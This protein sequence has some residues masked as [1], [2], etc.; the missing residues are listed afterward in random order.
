MLLACVVD[1]DKI[2]GYPINNI[3]N[4][5]NDYLSIDF[6]G[7]DTLA[8]LHLRAYATCEPDSKSGGA[9]DETT[10]GIF[11]FWQQPT[12][13]SNKVRCPA[14]YTVTV[15]RA[16]IVVGGRRLN[17][18]IAG[19]GYLRVLYADDDLRVFVAPKSTTDDRWEKAGLIVVQVRADL[20]DPDAE[21]LD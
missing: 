11:A 18:P 15:N 4:N 9:S 7:K 6:I 20:F 2:I 10:G 1:N 8:A 5:L 12:M 16:S 17:I 21:R 13:K 14:D 19:T 3:N